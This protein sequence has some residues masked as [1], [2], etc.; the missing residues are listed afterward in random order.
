MRAAPTSSEAGAA[1]RRRVES[2]PPSS[3]EPSTIR[4]GSA[5]RLP[6]ET[7]ILRGC[8]SSATG[9]TRRSTPSV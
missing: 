8:A 6:C 9:M 2:G 7:A 1:L 5:F 3:D 4:A